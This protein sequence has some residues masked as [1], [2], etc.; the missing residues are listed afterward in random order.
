MNG[1]GRW[2]YTLEIRKR[3]LGPVWSNPRKAHLS[4]AMIAK[5]MGSEH[6]IDPAAVVL[7]RGTVN[8]L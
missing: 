2:D 6:K 4:F 8:A 1:A 3:F 7:R 5:C